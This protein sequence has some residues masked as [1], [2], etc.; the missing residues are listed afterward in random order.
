MTIA[1]EI[2]SNN[3]GNMKGLD[4]FK[5]KFNPDKLYLISNTGLTWQE[6]L[7]INPIDLF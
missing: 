7:K 4:V 1:I 3:S 5:N 6:F 2:K